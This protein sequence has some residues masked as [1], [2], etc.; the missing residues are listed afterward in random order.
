[1]KRLLPVLLVF[2]VFLASAGK[3]F[4]LPPCLE[5]TDTYWDNCFGTRTYADGGKYVGEWKD[6]KWNGQGTFTYADGR[7]KAGVWDKGE[8]KNAQNADNKFLFV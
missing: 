2:G 8:F 6:D 4:A 3:S 1:M 5:H 7:V